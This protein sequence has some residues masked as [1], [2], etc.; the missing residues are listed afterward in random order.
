MMSDAVLDM[1]TTTTFL[2]SRPSVLGCISA[3]FPGSSQYRPSELLRVH[4]STF[5]QL[6]AFVL[7]HLWLGLV[8]V[9]EHYLVELFGMRLA[10]KIHLK[11]P[12]GVIFVALCTCD[13]SS[14]DNVLEE[15][16]VSRIRLNVLLELR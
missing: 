7:R 11:S 2:P 6:L 8:P 13:C 1:P 10:V 9:T 12:F 15:I 3:Q 16:K 5:V 4:Q 14:E